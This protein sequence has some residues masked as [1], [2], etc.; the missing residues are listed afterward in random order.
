MT[1]AVMYDHNG[2]A[3]ELTSPND[4]GEQFDQQTQR[5]L[6]DGR[7]AHTLWWGTSDQGPDP[8]GDVNVD[9]LRLRIDIDPEMGRAAVRWLPDGTHVQELEPTTTLTVIESADAADVIIPAELA[10]VS[11]PTARTI[12]VSFAADGQR[13]TGVSWS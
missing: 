3:Y 9:S 2:V 5:I 6:R 10:V 12:A 7:S 1:I 11:I 8:R 13:P 4:A